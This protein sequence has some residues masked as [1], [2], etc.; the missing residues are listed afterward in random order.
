MGVGGVVDKGRARR[1]ARDALC[2]EAQIWFGDD[3]YGHEAAPAR[4]KAQSIFPG[5]EPLR[6]RQELE[7]V[8]CPESPLTTQRK[9]A[10]SSG[11]SAQEDRSPRHPSLG[12]LR[13]DYDYP[14][15][16]GDIDHPASYG[17]PVHYRVVPG[18]S[19]ELCQSG[20]LPD[21]VKRAFIKAIR[22]LDDAKGISAITSDCGFMMWFQQL[23]RLHT[24]KPVFLSS[25]VAIPTVALTLSRRRKIAVLTANSVSLARMTD[26]VRR[27]CGGCTFG[28]RLVLVG[29]QDVDGFEAVALG[30]KVEMQRVGP[31]VVRL[32][33]ESC[34]QHDIGAFIFEC[35][36]LPPFSEAVRRATGL[37]VFDAISCCDFFMSG[38]T[39]HERGTAGPDWFA[40][41][42][43]MQEKYELGR[44][45]GL[46]EK[47]RLNT[48]EL[49]RR[50]AIANAN[51]AR[52][53]VAATSL[54][55]A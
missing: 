55:A 21:D 44:E 20:V 39:R 16:P 40:A 18:M 42:D 50:R 41:W 45:L 34:A 13:L 32:A 43:G 48:T 49:G 1:P 9:R 52:A 17:Y 29:C 8:C 53:A 47:A 12:V 27:D 26:L 22:W 23:A 25:L 11:V 54:V 19:F 38:Y 30:E 4:R 10:Q 36:E 7:A 15:A 5:E 35:T 46:Q 6:G 51:A 31:G 2:R 28:D 37:P 33:L 3:D 14:A 24:K